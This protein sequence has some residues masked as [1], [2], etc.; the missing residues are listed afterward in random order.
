MQAVP[1]RFDL[2]SGHVCLGIDGPLHVHPS[3]V[4]EVVGL[5]KTFSR[6]R[7]AG[8]LKRMAASKPK[9]RIGCSVTSAAN[10]ERSTVAE[11]CVSP[12]TSGIREHPARLP[13]Q[14]NGWMVHGSAAAGI[15]ENAAAWSKAGSWSSGPFPTKPNGSFGRF[16][17]PNFRGANLCLALLGSFVR[18]KQSTS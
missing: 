1:N 13:H 7:G 10:S 3:F 2:Q 14:P 12:S 18:K 6:R 9:R 4:V 16:V 11:S 15:R 5:P 17:T 8:S